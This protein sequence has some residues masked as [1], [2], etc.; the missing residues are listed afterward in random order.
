MGEAN[1]DTS[2][3]GTGY[4]AGWQIDDSAVYDTKQ[5]V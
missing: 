1:I 5:G 3:D 2:T 4:A